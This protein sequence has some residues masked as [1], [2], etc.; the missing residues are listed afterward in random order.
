MDIHFH[1][2][3]GMRRAHAI[4][5]SHA[6]EHMSGC[7]AHDAGSAREERPGGREEWRLPNLHVTIALGTGANSRRAI[8]HQAAPCSAA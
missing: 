4:S 5:M 7:Q 2:M 3:D 6:E 1:L 8:G